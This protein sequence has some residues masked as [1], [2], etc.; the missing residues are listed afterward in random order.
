MDRVH[1]SGRRRPMKGNEPSL[2]GMK[3]QTVSAKAFR[4]YGHYPPGVLLLDTSQDKVVAIAD[5]VGGSFQARL[6]LLLEPLIQHI[7]QINVR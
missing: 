7:V 1:G 4:Q 5:Q 6:D 2:L 3:R